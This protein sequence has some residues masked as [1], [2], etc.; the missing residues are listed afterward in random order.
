[1]GQC[2]CRWIDLCHGAIG[3]LGGR[4]RC[5]IGVQHVAPDGGGRCGALD[6]TLKCIMGIVPMATQFVRNHGD[7]T[8]QPPHARSGHGGE[9]LGCGGHWTTILVGALANRC[10]GRILRLGNGRRGA[11]CL[12]CHHAFELRSHFLGRGTS[13]GECR[14][15]YQWCLLDACPAHPWRPIGTARSSEGGSKQFL[16]G[17]G[18]SRDRRGHNQNGCYKIHLDR[19]AD[20]TTTSCFGQTAI[21]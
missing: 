7:G 3:S 15:L 14:C 10:D 4:T 12:G 13:V 2:Q 8:I 16:H 19:G 18:C 9:C 17:C 21:E 11:I 1:M 5:G 20:F 6:S